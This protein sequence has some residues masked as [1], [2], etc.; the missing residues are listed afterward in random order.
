VET[1]KLS[2]FITQNID[3]LKLDVEGA[4][5]EVLK[6]CRD[7]LPLVNHLFV[8]FHATKDRRPEELVTLLLNAG[9]E[10]TAHADNKEVPLNMLTHRKPTL[11][12]IEARKK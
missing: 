9:F 2:A 4:E 7:Q 6:E 5:I 12:M 8:E 10:L 11:Y 1:V 3:I